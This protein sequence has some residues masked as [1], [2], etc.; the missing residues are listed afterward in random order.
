MA[1]PLGFGDYLK[2]AFS[3]RASLPLLG[4]LPANWMAL[5]I[6]GVLGIAN[7]GFWLLGAAGEL[8][9]LFGMASSARFQKLIQGERLL[10][11][12]ENYE[13][14]IGDTL[15]RLSADSRQRYRQ[16]LD[17]CRRILGLRQD[18]GDSLGNVGEL[19]NHGLNQMLRIFLRLLSSR[20]AIMANL[21]NLNPDGLRGE[22]TRLEERL[23]GIDAE[24]QPALARSL[25]STLEIT[26][27]R[28]DN[29]ARARESLDVI[30]AEL[31]RIEGQVELIREETAV[32]GGADQ[33]SSRLDQVSSSMQETSLWMEQHADLLGD[34]GSELDSPVP[35]LPRLPSALQGE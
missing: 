26:G 1:R 30:D 10:A 28:L 12:Q 17:Q 35:D 25:R 31:R 23:E 22:I 4:Q 11:V 27:K 15:S 16:L 6:F 8:T 21:H 19:R 7:P 29:F 3:R 14:R 18:R 2:E 13:A 24:A 34:L 5:G 32:S 33:L 9:Y 20:R